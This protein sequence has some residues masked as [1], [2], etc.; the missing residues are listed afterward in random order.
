MRPVCAYK[1][2]KASIP[3][4]NHCFLWCLAS[5]Y[6]LQPTQCKK[7][8]VCSI[9]GGIEHP[10]TPKGPFLESPNFRPSASTKGGC[11][12]K[13]EGVSAYPRTTPTTSNHQKLHN[14]RAGSSGNSLAGRFYVGAPSC[15]QTCSLRQPN[16]KPLLETQT[17]LGALP[18]STATSFP[19]P[20]STTRASSAPSS[21]LSSS[22]FSRSTGVLFRWR[23]G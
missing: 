9:S 16:I 21:S 10:Q 1:T 13:C 23:F 6:I 15:T 14:L 20:T 22:S 3:L 5:E 12:S 8:G 19:C 18:A 4:L 11:R 2:P 7:P 17:K